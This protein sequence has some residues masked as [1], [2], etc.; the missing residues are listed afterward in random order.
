MV[1]DQAKLMLLHLMKNQL[2]DI[3]KIHLQVKNPF[4]SKY[5][6][7]IQGREKVQIKKIKNSTA[8]IDYWQAIGDVYE[9]LEDGNPKEKRRVFMMFLVLKIRKNYLYI[10]NNLYIKK[11]CK[12]KHVNLLLI[13][14]E[15]KGH[16]LLS[17]ISIRLFMI[18]H[19]I[20]EKIIFAV[21]LYIFLVQKEY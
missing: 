18:I 3:D 6:L 11:Y 20:V 10:K 2:P 13:E 17:K 1:L 15:R 4:E 5:Q 16:M 14:E 21:I 9:H 8:F 19:F 7:P 12:E